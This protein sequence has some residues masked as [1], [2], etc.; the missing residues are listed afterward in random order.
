MSELNKLEQPSLPL[1]SKVTGDALLKTTPM[2]QQFLELK[3]ENED[4]LLFFRMGDFYEL[5]FD[6]AVIA[7]KELDIALTSRGKYDGKPV[8]MCGV[9][10][11]AYMPYL[12]KLTKKTP[13]KTNEVLPGSSQPQELGSI[14]YKDTNT[15]ETTQQTQSIDTTASIVTETFQSE[16]KILPQDLSLIHI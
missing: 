3:V 15:N 13:D 10:F 9:P 5:F 12:E 16:E 14:S 6:D 7:S 8:P 2:F 1:L 4:C 11:H